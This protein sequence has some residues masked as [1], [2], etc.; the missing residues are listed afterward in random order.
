MIQMDWKCVISENSKEENK[1]YSSISKEKK[2]IVREREHE[3][4]LLECFIMMSIHITSE[5]VKHSHIH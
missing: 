3:A 2:K 4:D 5:E 1:V